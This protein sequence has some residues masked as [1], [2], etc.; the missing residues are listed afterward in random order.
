MLLLEL[1]CKECKDIY[2]TVGLDRSLVAA[3]YKDDPRACLA[4][5]LTHGV[6]DNASYMIIA[7]DF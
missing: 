6:I 1:Y 7:I 2:Q 5:F 3:L 4:L